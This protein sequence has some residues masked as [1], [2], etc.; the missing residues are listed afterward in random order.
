MI[1]RGSVKLPPLSEWMPH[2][3]ITEELWAAALEAEDMQLKKLAALIAV[4]SLSSH[5]GVSVDSAQKRHADRM[6]DAFLAM[7]YMAVYDIQ[8]PEPG[9]EMQ[10]EYDELSDEDKGLVDTFRA[11]KDIL[12]VNPVEGVVL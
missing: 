2:L 10:V 12:K 1:L 4:S 3:S 6:K 8:V 9:E 5:P 7:P 11:W